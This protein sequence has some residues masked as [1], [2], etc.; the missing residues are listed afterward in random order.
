MEEDGISVTRLEQALEQHQPAFLYT[1]PSYQNPGGQCMSLEKRNTLIELAEAHDFLIV[2][3]EVYQLLHFYDVPP[4]AFGTR[5]N[6]EAVISLGS[7]SK[8]LA[9]GLRLGWVQASAS[10]CD[11]LLTGGMINSGGSINHYAS[12]VVRHAIGLGLLDEHLAQ[13]RRKYGSRVAAMDIALKSEFGSMA[14]WLTPQGGYFFWVRFAEE[15]DVTALRE[16]AR[17]LETGFQPGDIFSVNGRLSNCL[18]LSFAHY[19]EAEIAE[20][21]QRMRPLFD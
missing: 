8:I 21:I 10:R 14:E 16:R 11:R 9:P 12:H 4:P 18:R 7:F 17:E 15:T 2:A 5:V 19:D 6:S 1:I 13:L 3:D 20:G